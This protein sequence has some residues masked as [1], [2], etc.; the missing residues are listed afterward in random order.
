MSV[1]A[2]LA[3]AEPAGLRV[4]IDRVDLRT[5]GRFQ[6]VDVTELVDERVRRSRVR[7][8]LVSVQTAHTT[9]AV[10]VN[11]NE[12]LLIEDVRRLLERLVPAD[13]AYGHDDLEARSPRVAPDERRN[14]CAHCRAV[15][16]PVSVTL[17]VVGGRMDLGR[18]QR[19][20]LAELDGGQKR[21][22]SI[23]VLGEGGEP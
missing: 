7:C 11:E 21:T 2:T 8:G 19:V 15:L 9:T 13:A 6:V 10:F 17:N 18:W 5:Q 14:G 12:P 1:V 4:V 16:L 20:L 3:G 22:L 23:L